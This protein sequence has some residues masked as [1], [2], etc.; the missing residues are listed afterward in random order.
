MMRNKYYYET[1]GAPKQLVRRPNVLSYPIKY[2]DGKPGR[3]WVVF[4]NPDIAKG[5]LDEDSN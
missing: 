2:K 5:V 1:T 3:Y 4:P